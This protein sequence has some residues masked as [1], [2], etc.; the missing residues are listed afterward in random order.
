VTALHEQGTIAT[1]NV[2]YVSGLLTI[3]PAPLTI[4]AVDAQREQGQENPDF[5]VSYEGFRNGEDETVLTTPPTVVCLAT[6]ESPVGTYEI[7]VYGAEAGNYDI[8]YLQGTLTVVTPDAVTLLPESERVVD[9]YSA[10]GVRVS[11]SYADELYRLSLRPGIY[12]IRY[13]DGSVRK[14]LIN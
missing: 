8:S 11:R 3:E 10:S 13:T 7:D 4:A 1:D 9:I 6:P 14:V 2:T 12:I 5:E